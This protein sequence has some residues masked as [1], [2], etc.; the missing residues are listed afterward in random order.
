M[1]LQCTKNL[2]DELKIKPVNTKTENPMFCWHCNVIK[3]N[4]RKIVVV[5]ND[6]MRCCVVLYGLKAKDFK[7]FGEL[8]KQGIK[9]VL[10][11]E[12][13]DENIIKKYLQE[14]GEIIYTKTQG[15]SIVGKMNGITRDLQFYLNYLNPHSIIQIAMSKEANEYYSKGI[16]DAYVRPY[17]EIERCLIEFY[18]DKVKSI[19]AIEIQITLE[20]ENYKTYRNVI[21]HED[22]DFKRLHKIIQLVFNWKDYHLHEFS[23]LKDDEVIQRIISH[24]DE[25][26]EYNVQNKTWEQHTRLRDVL[27]TNRKLIYTYDFGDDWKHRI[28]FV[29]YIEDC[30]NRFCTCTEGV[31]Y[32]PPED[33]GGQ[34]GFLEFMK[35]IENPTHPEHGDM[36]AWSEGLGF[37]KFNGELIN[38]RL[39][40]IL[41]RI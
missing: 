33:V 18:G 1:K 32:T 19:R 26:D 23:V 7:Q 22:I 9:E 6:L 11:S 13:I 2:F 24:E 29:R 25:F 17:E 38:H 20:I 12:H 31:G 40:R 21:L 30:K 39:K 28:D 4:R 35:I 5:V 14:S 34:Y 3:V 27:N 37:E 16:D 8:V 41:F 10:K 15:R 36:L